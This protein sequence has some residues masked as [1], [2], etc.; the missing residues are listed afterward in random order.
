MEN[1]ILE[2]EISEEETIHFTS[3]VVHDLPARKEIN[4]LY[5]LLHASSIL[6]SGMVSAMLV[7]LF[8]YLCFVTKDYGNYIRT[9]SVFC[10]VYWGSIV[11]N[12]FRN[13]NG[14][15]AYKQMLANNGGKPV[16]NQ[17]TFLEESIRV[18]N[19][20]TEAVS[21]HPYTS[22]CFIAETNRF[23]LI[24]RELNQCTVVSKESLTGGTTEELLDFLAEKCTGMKSREMKTPKAGRI[25]Q[26][27]LNTLW[28][29]GLAAALVLYFTMR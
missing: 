8:V 18:Q 2:P 16:R 25:T 22:I 9:F 13:R 12:L 5:A 14:G 26:W 17:I 10:L 15:S 6:R 1:E 7:F 3:E 24:Y 20:Y 29:L 19:T 27:V 23:Y 4:R 11:I 28:V 21:E